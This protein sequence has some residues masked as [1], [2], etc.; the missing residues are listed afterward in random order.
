M[1]ALELCP[2]D[3]L[4]R[5]LVNLK[6]AISVGER[7]KYLVEAAEGMAFLQKK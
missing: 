3:S 4:L 2:G 6:A 7:I 1:I 5:H